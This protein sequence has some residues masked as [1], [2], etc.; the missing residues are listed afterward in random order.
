MLGL[1]PIWALAIGL[2]YAHI[3]AVPLSKYRTKDG[4]MAFVF[5]TYLILSG[6]FMVVLAISSEAVESVV[7]ACFVGM[8]LV[9]LTAMLSW[10]VDKCERLTFHLIIERWDIPVVWLLLAGMAVFAYLK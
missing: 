4:I 3:R 7:V 8:T 10:R 2:G 1:N 6:L 5:G 9:V